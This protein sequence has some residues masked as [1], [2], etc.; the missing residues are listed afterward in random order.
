MTDNSELVIIQCPYCEMYTSVFKKD[1]NCAIFRH[2]VYKDT[3]KPIDPHST[4]EQCEKL[5]KSDKI[6]GCAKPFQIKFV[7]DNPVVT[8]CDYI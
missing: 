8:K 7:D 5:L 3:F 6:F 1:I 4:L 2:A